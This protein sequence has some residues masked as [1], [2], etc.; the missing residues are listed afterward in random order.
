MQKTDGLRLQ[1]VPQPLRGFVKKCESVLVAGS[2]T[3]DAVIYALIV[4]FVVRVMVV[5]RYSEEMH[6]ID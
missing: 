3:V 6:F 2:V 4:K 5:I 1:H